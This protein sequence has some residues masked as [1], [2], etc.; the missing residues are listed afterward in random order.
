MPKRGSG[1][2]G[3]GQ[4]KIAK[5]EPAREAVI[6]PEHL[7]TLP[8]WLDSHEIT[9]ISK[10]LGKEQTIGLAKHLGGFAIRR[11][12][13]KFGIRAVI[14]NADFILQWHELKRKKGK[15]LT[16]EDIEEALVARGFPRK[17]PK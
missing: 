9:R 13:D 2:G 11:L 12:I 17:P 4:Q 14:R 8:R 16:M 5:I 7:G 15:K 3:K 10:A 6:A 1:K